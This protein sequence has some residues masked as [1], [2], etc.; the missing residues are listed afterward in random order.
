MSAVTMET[1]GG[2]ERSLFAVVLTTV[3]ATVPLL[4]SGGSVTSYGVGMAVADWP[5]TQNQ[6]MFL[7]PFLQESFGV[8]VEHGHR[9]LGSLVGMLAIALAT[10]AIFVERR[11]WVR[12][13]AIA[14]LL[15]VCCQ[16]VLGGMRVL[17][18]ARFGPAL[19]MT[20][21]VFAQATFGCLVALAAFTSRSWR[22]AS[23]TVH[24]EA[25][26]LRGASAALT[27]LVFLQIVFGA[28]LRHFGQTFVLHLLIAAA[29]VV[30]TLWIAFVTVIHEPLRRSM[31]RS[32]FALVAAVLVQVF[33]GVGVLAMVGLVPPGYGKA[34]S[35]AEAMIA[36]A[37]VVGGALL[38]AS[39]LVF[40]LGT[41]RYV[42]PP[43]HS[44]STASRPVVGVTG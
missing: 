9:L 40:T 22:Q 12:N 39:S 27:S 4:F 21:G 19:A 10:A 23:T 25:T 20:H 30:L 34:P 41:F 18:N 5:T 32:T 29:I 11:R 44:E 7:F 3:V 8:K 26:R 13:L 33:L 28:H 17:L 14:A 42:L 24:P 1:W 36:T 16:G 43:A 35:H 37:H 6:N 15:M 2:R 38:F 31:P